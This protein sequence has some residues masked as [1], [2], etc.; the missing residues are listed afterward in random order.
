[1]ET[2]RRHFIKT[3]M[4]GVAMGPVVTRFQLFSP[5]GIPTR[6]LGNT[7]ERVS[8]IGYGG[9]DT[10]VGKS[11]GESIRHIHRAIDGGI[12]FFDNAWEY[13]DGRSEEVMG[14]ALAQEGY[15]NRVFLM[16]KVCA[17]DYDGVKKQVD[18]SLKRLQTDHV[19]LL[20]FHSIQYPDDPQRIFDPEKGGMKA[21]LEA[22]QEGKLRFIGFSG[23][24]FPEKHL[25]MIN[26]PFEW[27]TVQM[28]LN[29]LDAH[30]KSF[31]H[32]VLPVLNQKN[33][34]A[35]GMKSLTGQD[36]RLPREL[37]ISAELC[38]RYALSLPVSTV[39]CGT[40]TFEELESDM[41]I[42]RD[43]KPLSEEEIGYLLDIAREPAR[44]GHIEEYKNPLGFYGC[45][46]H[47]KIL[48]GEKI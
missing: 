9:W 38:R 4:T 36:A 29:I 35:L 5:A 15:R 24:M 39:I 22:R 19:D 47:K 18:E 23:H 37:N 40:Q 12:T 48:K 41:A 11:T 44:D 30:Y 8:I 25:E 16:T 31:Q 43:F 26:M 46:Y 17:R 7:G 20:Q 1:M 28:P 32:Q 21:V 45:S 34:G 42:A 33:I 27:N 10:V 13:H 3:L 2:T 14:K 6:P